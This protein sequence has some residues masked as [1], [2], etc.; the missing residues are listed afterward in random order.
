[1]KSGT[2]T[3]TIKSRTFKFYAESIRQAERITLS[4]AR[5]TTGKSCYISIKFPKA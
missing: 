4:L 1:M 5:K 2:Y 3:V